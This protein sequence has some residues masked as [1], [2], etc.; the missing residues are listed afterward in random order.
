MKLS[1]TPAVFAAALIAAGALAACLG[2][3]NAANKAA[4]A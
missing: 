2:A 4:A 1:R 3:S